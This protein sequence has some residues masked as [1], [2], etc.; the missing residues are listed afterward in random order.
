MLTDGLN[1][2][3]F[4]CGNYGQLAKKLALLIQ[5]PKLRFSISNSGSELI[6]QFDWKNVALETKVV[7][8]TLLREGN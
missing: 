3:I 5:D 1:G 2:L 4:E 6:N 8:E 7:Y